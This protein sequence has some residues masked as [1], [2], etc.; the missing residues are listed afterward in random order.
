MTF[1][2]GERL[3]VARDN[4]TVGEALEAAENVDRRTGAMLLIDES[5]ILSGLLTDADLRRAFV[6]RKN[7]NIQATPV[8]ELMTK[9]P[10]SIKRGDLASEAEA[11]FN[12]YRIDEL[13]VVDDTGKPVGVLDVQDLLGVKTLKD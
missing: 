10:K 1:R 4:L 12:Q 5:G 3:S 7:E 2:N 9:N 8:S 13:P 11:I 6:E